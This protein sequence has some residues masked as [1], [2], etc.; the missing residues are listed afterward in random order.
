MPK[1]IYYFKIALA[2]IFML[3]IG[4]F[5]LS[6]LFVTLPQIMR[7][8]LWLAS[9]SQGFLE[10]DKSRRVNFSA[11][12]I[13]SGKSAILYFLPASGKFNI[14]D[15]FTTAVNIDSP[16]EAVNAVTADIYFSPEHLEVVDIFTE[17]SLFNLW[18]VPP[19]YSNENGTINFVG[20][21]PTPGFTGKNGVI[22]EIVFRVK[23]A[24]YTELTAQNIEI[25]ANDGYGTD[26]FKEVKRASYSLGN[27]FF[28]DGKG[29]QIITADF[30]EFLM[31]LCK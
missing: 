29:A 6:R 22:A 20:G 15:I 21:L 17:D 9:V 1:D 30:L 5:A 13:K 27:G 23:R 25:L 10:A 8:E 18:V 31:R 4:G 16:T 19:K 11:G 14:G 3:V 2:T 7:G 28:Q 12:P 26:V 24:G